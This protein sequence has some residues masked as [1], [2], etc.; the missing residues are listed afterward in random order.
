M[1]E[2]HLT[3]GDEHGFDP[4]SNTLKYSDEMISP[5]NDIVAEAAF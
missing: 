2:P 1:Q 4:K 3:S 5:E